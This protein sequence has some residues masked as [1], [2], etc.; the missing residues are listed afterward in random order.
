MRRPEDG[1]FGELVAAH[2]QALRRT[3]Y[4]MCGDWHQAEHLVQI[5]FIKLHAAWG[6]VQRDGSLDAYLRKT[7]LRTCIDEK[8]RGWWRRESP[9]SGRLPELPDPAAQPSTD[10][11][12]LVAALRRIPPGQRAALVLRF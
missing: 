9:A 11:D 4:L 7:L 1:E 10:R 2:S 6:R 3:A 5:T 8:R 12:V